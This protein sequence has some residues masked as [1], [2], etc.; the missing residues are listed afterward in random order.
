[1]QI[2][3]SFKTDPRKG[4]PASNSL[5][6]CPLSSSPVKI[7]KIASGSGGHS[8]QQLGKGREG[9]KLVTI[10]GHAAT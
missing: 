2:Q 3:N 7:Q 4:N 10:Q 5:S 6:F 9:T 8:I 1:M